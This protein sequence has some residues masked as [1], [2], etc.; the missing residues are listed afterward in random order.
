MRTR[1]L[2]G[3]SAALLA[4]LLSPVGPMGSA[5]AAGPGG[6][7]SLSGRT[8]KKLGAIEAA[9]VEAT[10]GGLTRAVVLTDA[11]LADDDLRADE[12][13]FAHE[14]RGRARAALGDNDAAA[15]SDLEAALATGRV[16]DARASAMLVIVLDLLVRTDDP[17]AAVARFE[18]GEPLLRE[19][20]DFAPAVVNVVPAYSAQRRA[21]HALALLSE[22]AEADGTASAELHAMR[23]AIALQMRR[24]DEAEAALGAH[25]ALFAA[26]PPYVAPARA[27]LADLRAVERPAAAA[28]REAAQNFLNDEATWRSEN[29]DTQPIL[30]VPPQGFETCLRRTRGKTLVVVHLQFDVAETGETTNIRVLESDDNCFDASAVGSVAT[31]RY[32]PKFVDGAPAPRMGVR[33]S[34]RYDIDG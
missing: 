12:R 4:C 26:P 15:L 28:L 19:Q 14:Y 17:E 3:A 6:Q 23:Y 9:L 5:E 30:R 8:L 13:S 34:I 32:A 33:S 29:R 20:N 21:D 18:A 10:R 16:S 27:T 1:W 22:A 7:P 31:W 11:L 25:E 24:M 2:T